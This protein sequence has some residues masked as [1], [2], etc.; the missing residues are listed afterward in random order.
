MGLA[1]MG[2]AAMAGDGPSTLGE[3]AEKTVTI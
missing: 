2:L 3:T 1:T